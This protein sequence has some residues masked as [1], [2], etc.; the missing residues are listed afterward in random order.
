M[1]DHT[2]ESLIN[3]DI[4]TAR[5]ALR[6]SN[7]SLDDLATYCEKDYV[8]CANPRQSMENTKQYAAQSLASVAYQINTLAGNILELLDKQATKLADMEANVH[9]I[10]MVRLPDSLSLGVY[11]D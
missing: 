7:K 9:H 8:G 11:R 3:Q 6:N 1:A 10:N 5:Q 4:P 2:L